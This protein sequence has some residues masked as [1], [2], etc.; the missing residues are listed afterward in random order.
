[1][2][3]LSLTQAALQV[4]ARCGVVYRSWRKVACLIVQETIV[5]AWLNVQYLQI[6]ALFIVQFVLY[7]YIC[8][9]F[10]I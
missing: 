1:M 8:G 3:R 6:I 2:K 7:S 10:N 9:G 4:G 5:S